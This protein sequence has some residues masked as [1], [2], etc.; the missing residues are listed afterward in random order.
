MLDVRW[1]LSAALLC[2]L[3]IL[4]TACATKA[5]DANPSPTFDMPAVFP[6]AEE[7]ASVLPTPWWSSFDDPML[8]SLVTEGLS[9][10]LT[11]QQAAARIAQSEALFRQAQALRWPQVDLQSSGSR[12][13]E[14]VLDREGGQTLQLQD[15]PI[16]LSSGMGD[17]D[18]P[19]SAVKQPDLGNDPEQNQNNPQNRGGGAGPIERDE[20]ERNSYRNF[21]EARMLLQWELDF[22]GRLRNAARAEAEALEAAFLDYEAVRLSLS[23]QIAEAYFVA[24]EQRLQLALLEQQ[25]DSAETFLELLELRFLQGSASSVDVLQQR[26]QVAEIVAEI[27][28]AEA[29]LGLLENR[30][31]VLAGKPADGINRTELDELSLPEPATLAGVALPAE[32]LALRPDL[33]AAQRRVV[34]AD[35]DVAVAVAERLPQFTLDG[36]L[37]V[38]GG[39]GVTTLTAIGGLG[40]FQPL[41]DWGRRRAAVGAAESIQLQQL[42]AFSQQYLLAIEEV[43]TTLWQEARQRELVA[44]LQ[45]REAILER[46]LE[47]TRLRYSQGVTDYLPVLTALQA[48]Q[49]VQRAVL[50]ERSNLVVLRIRLFRAA[51]GPTREATATASDIAIS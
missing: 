9:N 8:D 40:L 12:V 36:S 33:R 16:D 22:W 17:E 23:A 31:D 20:E 19:E 47:Q 4:T 1:P 48:L 25:R 11:L 26:G 42:L 5:V 27:P 46:T 24:I 15:I 37:I 28:V 29:Q 34:A 32:L 21:Y 49:E 38:D 13:F 14:R 35:Y 3:P 44:A 2:G 39:A 51:G 18:S 10:N 7:A 43:D 45:E 41:L 6:S 30:L 50:R